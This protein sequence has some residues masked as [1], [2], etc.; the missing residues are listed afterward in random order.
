[1]MLTLMFNDA[2]DI[3]V[4]L[5]VGIDAMDTIPL[6]HTPVGMYCPISSTLNMANDFLRLTQR[7]LTENTVVTFSVEAATTLMMIPSIQQ[8]AVI[9]SLSKR[10]VALTLVVI[11]I[12]SGEWDCTIMKQFMSATWM[13]QLVI[14]VAALWMEKLTLMIST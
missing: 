2:L 13:V 9:M 1:M 11:M 3:S 14:L 4:E 12:L 6:Q 7:M 5:A 8:V 10:K